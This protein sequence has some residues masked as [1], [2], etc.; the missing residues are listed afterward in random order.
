MARRINSAIVAAAKA[1]VQQAIAQ[2]VAT[3]SERAVEHLRGRVARRASVATPPPPRWL[4]S[5]PPCR[6]SSLPLSVRPGA[7]EGAWG[8]EPSA[9]IA[10][11]AEAAVQCASVHAT[12]ATV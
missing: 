7:A 6:L 5:K 12:T 3:A 2:A 4:C 1:V 10:V 8:G 9:A 11:A